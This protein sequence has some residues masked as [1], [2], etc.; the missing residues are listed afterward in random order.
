M[1]PARNTARRRSS[2][3]ALSWEVE[4]LE[5]ELAA[6]REREQ[7]ARREVEESR[8]RFERL[9]AASRSFAHSLS[10]GRRQRKDIGRYLRAEHAVDRALAEAYNLEAVAASILRILA[11]HL[12]WRAALLWI[13]EEETLRCVAVWHR[14]NVV[15]DG[16]AQARLRTNLARGEHLP[17]KAVAINAPVWEG[18]HEAGDPVDGLGSA[19]AFP[20]TQ[21]HGV[22]G[23]VELLGGEIGNPSEELLYAV[24][25]IGDRLG[26]FV[27]RQRAQEEI[28][29]AEAR[30][31]LA[32]EAGQLGLL[33]WNVATGESQCSGA[34]ARI[35]DL[36]L[37]GG[38]TLTYE[39]LLARVHND[40]R[41]R[42]KGTFDASITDGTPYDLEFRITAPGGVRWIHLK[43]RVHKNRAGESTRV[44]GIMLDITE[45]KQAE[46]ES[47]RLRFL[48]ASI[49]AEAAERDRISRELH[50]R[51]AHSMGVAH[52]SLQLYEALAE[53]D[54][55]R[56]H[57]KLHTAQE[58]TKL[59]LEQT[60]NLSM[61]LR[62][63]E[64]ENGLVPALQDLLE[65][66]VPDDVDAELSISG[67][68]SGLS[69]H[70]RGQLYL[71]LREAVRNAVKHSGCRQLKVGLDMTP[72][73]VSGY[74]EDD[75]SG[76]A[77]DGQSGLGL[78]SVMERA[79][80]L[81]G[82]AE[83]YDSPQGGAGVR[84]LLPLRN[85]KGE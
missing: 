7:R 2:Q 65:V 77:G 18:P 36:P 47:E 68:E 75:G 24:R 20:I 42:V 41:E 62:R 48:E 44:L 74:V 57:G 30:L 12:G 69:G 40:D 54:P 22:F 79:A 38:T 83:V 78:R 28:S 1:N 26:H 67:A 51:V 32:T 16:F 9:L 61:E 39:D 21:S 5:R 50:D 8:E 34:F 56:A 3:S 66:A 60:R 85:G 73:E 76:L 4:R 23:A 84:V 81:Q 19:L 35:F 53:E 31:R 58:M 49:H 11:E 46:Q 52:Q 82:T 6:S 59:A 13:A 17:G 33:D 71:I 55:E 10:G 72:E 45:K 43:G 64:T 15:P 63:S 25:L 29:E 37:E 27:E 14:P 80:L 70:Q